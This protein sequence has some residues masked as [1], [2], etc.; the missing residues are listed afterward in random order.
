M[1]L[2]QRGALQDQIVGGVVEDL[3]GAG[4]GRQGTSTLGYDFAAFADC[5]GS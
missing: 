5:A 1:R 3:I 2:A 4:Q